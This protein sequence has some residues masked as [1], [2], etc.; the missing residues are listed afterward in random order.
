MLIIYNLFIR[1]Y[2]SGILISSL[3]NKK[4]KLWIE[5]RKNLFKELEKLDHFGKTAWFHCASLGEFEQGRPVIEKFKIQNPDYKI[6]VTFFSPSGYEIRKNYAGADVVC[7]L[8]LDT[9]KN[10]RKFIEVTQP[11]IAV[12]IKYEFWHHY[13]NEL[14]KKHIPAFLVSANFRREQP[15]FKWYGAFWRSM[16]KKFNHLFVQNES[17]K[18]L[19]KNIGFDNITAA[20]DTRFD[21]VYKVASGPKVISRINEF[22]D[23]KKLIVA[24][25][26]WPKDETFL[27]DAF[28][29]LKIKNQNL[30]LLI[31]PHEIENKSMESIRNLFKN[32]SM[33]LYSQ[34][35]KENIT[36]TDILIIDNIGMLS[37]LY[38]YADIAYIGGGFGKGIHNILEAAAH[39]KP[40]IFGPNYKKFN[41]AAELIKAGGAFTVS[42]G[43]E[44]AETISNLLNEPAAT[45]AENASADYIGRNRG[46]TEAVVN[47]LSAVTG[48]NLIASV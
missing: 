27:Q 4:A 26:T 11:D 15:F 21:R 9:K 16:L 18:T 40:V 20:G 47:R 38:Q 39:G 6:V 43:E 28:L 45:A 29:N 46:A 48:G 10:A 41:E 25:S 31:A 34:A 37:S 17:S 36:A 23:D 3:F 33:T 8:P 35:D 12:F 13:L 22:K 42:N 24:G 14:E 19:L 5:G 32:F 30:K 1:L 44:L 7:Y 2:Y